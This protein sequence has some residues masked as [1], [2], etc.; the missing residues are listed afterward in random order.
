MSR[1]VFCSKLQKEAPG[2]N[3]PPLPGPLGEKI[4]NQ[5]SQ[6]AWN[7]WLAHQTMLINEYRLSLISPEAKTFLK[8]EMNKFLFGEGSDKPAGFTEE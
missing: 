5:V 7:A 6:E 3:T 4:Y 2:L 1:Q 8:D